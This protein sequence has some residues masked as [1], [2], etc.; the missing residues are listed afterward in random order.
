MGNK[1]F[2]IRMM[3]RNGFYTSFQWVTHCDVDAIPGDPRNVCNQKQ[4]ELCAIPG[5]P[6]TVCNQQQFGVGAIP[7]DPG[8]VCN[9]QPYDFGA[10]PE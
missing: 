5:D 8:N 1:H 3:N 10:I 6:R 9:Q 2:N 7:G 4:H